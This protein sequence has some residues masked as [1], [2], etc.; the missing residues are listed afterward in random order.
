MKEMFFLEILKHLLHVHK[1]GQQILDGIQ[2][3]MHL[4]TI[5]RSAETY[6]KY[7][8]SETSSLKGE[9]YKSRPNKA[10]HLIKCST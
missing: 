3:C 9:S 4:M 8:F 10:R 5:W 1:V 7:L 6:S 2:L